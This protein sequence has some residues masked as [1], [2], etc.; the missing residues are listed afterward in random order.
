MAS[1]IIKMPDIGEGIAQV[2]LV[3]WH[4]Q[5]GDTVTEDQ[6]LADVMTDKA[7]VE[8]PSPVAGKIMALGGEVGQQIPVGAELI[9]LEVE[10]A[11]NV[12]GDAP[13]HPVQRSAP[14]AAAQA[15][16]A[17]PA[18]CPSC[19]GCGRARARTGRVGT[20][21]GNAGRAADPHAAARLAAADA[22]ARRQTDRL[23]R[24]AA[25]RLGT[26]HRIAVRERQRPGRPHPARGPRR[27]PGRARPAGLQGAPARPMPNAT[28]KKRFP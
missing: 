19:A 11:G 24:R 12:K 21:R 27:V 7:T 14:P 16:P 9:R 18:G 26:G 1:Y 15:A 3:A 23:A 4:V 25:A 13:V 2:E 22:R 28:T 5:P 6:I 8:I 10:G 20:R 17:T